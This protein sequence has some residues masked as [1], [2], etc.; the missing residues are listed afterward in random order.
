MM[1]KK[2]K[3]YINIRIDKHTL[4]CI[5]WRL[6]MEIVLAHKQCLNMFHHIFWPA[7]TIWFWNST[8]D[9]FMLNPACICTGGPEERGSWSIWMEKC[10]AIIL[11]VVWLFKD[12]TK[13]PFT[14]IH[15]SYIGVLL[16]IFK[17]NIRTS[18]MYIM[19]NRNILELR[20]S[21]H[22]SDSDFIII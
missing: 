19:V 17:C 8:E 9:I 3:E 18:W 13:P 5:T 20:W 16:H 1:M 7:T 2:L 12:L 14:I 22:Y 4:S 15:T 10:N 6:L 11:I 21:W